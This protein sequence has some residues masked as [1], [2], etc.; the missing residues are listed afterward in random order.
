M[1]RFFTS[2]KTEWLPKTGY[3]SFSEAKHCIDDYIIGY[4]SK[5]RPH[6][7]NG[8]VTSNKSEYR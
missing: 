6:S 7:Y 3:Q 1:E 4:Y 8:G 5:I 2:L